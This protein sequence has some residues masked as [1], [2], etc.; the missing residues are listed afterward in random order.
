[1]S[2]DTVKN[3]ETEMAPIL[4][5]HHDKIL[6]DGKLFDI[7]RKVKEQSATFG[8]EE[9][10]LLDQLSLDF[11]LSGANLDEQSK[12][13][14]K[15]LNQQLSV[16]YT[17]FSHKLLR[18]ED[19]FIELEE[20]DLDGLSADIVDGLKEIAKSKEKSGYLVLNTRSYVQ[21]FLTFSSRRDLR[22]KVWRSFV[23]RGDNNDGN[24][25]KELIKSILKLRIKKAKLLGFQSHAHLQTVN[26][27]CKT[28]ER[29]ME[30]MMEVWNPTLQRVKEEV[31]D[32]QKLAGHKI[33]PWDYYYY[34]E[35]VRKQQ[36]DLDME[37]VNEYLELNNLRNALFY[38]AK[39]L[40]GLHF[41]EITDVPKFHN[42]VQ[43]FEVREEKT[44]KVIG[45]YYLDPF[46]RPGEKNSG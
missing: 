24:D 12:E 8:E 42:D 31:E 43:V 2:N 32:M 39:R 35:K 44:Q 13:K 15:D 22:E 27:M 37:T 19:T 40:F 28:P 10:R 7:I 38:C 18:D 6:L 45:L 46:A 11:I 1:M 16:L 21:P 14:L 17:E 4:T 3:L 9:Q 29:A 30:L 23:S 34:A 41:E 25:T 26:T 36:Y 33:E 5:A 20:G